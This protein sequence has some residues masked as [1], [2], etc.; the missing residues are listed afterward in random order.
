MKPTSNEITHALRSIENAERQD[1]HPRSLARKAITEWRSNAAKENL[2][3]V[4]ITDN[5][6]G[7]RLNTDEV[8][9]RSEPNHISKE[10]R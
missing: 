8:L 6:G 4:N 3:V 7:R 9:R 1:D 2:P 10:Q 5:K